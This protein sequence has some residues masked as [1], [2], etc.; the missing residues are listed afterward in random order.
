MNT[1]AG[2]IICRE[3][4]RVLSEEGIFVGL[5]G[6]LLYK[7]GDRKD[8]DIVIYRHRQNREPFETRDIHDLLEKCGLTEIRHYGFVTKAKFATFEVDIFNPESKSGTDEDEYG[9]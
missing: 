2:I 9:E 7:E 6:G 1:Q 4:Y 5:T 3:L 8:C